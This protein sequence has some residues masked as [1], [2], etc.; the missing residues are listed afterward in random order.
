MTSAADT[1]NS[2]RLRVLV[3]WN[4]TAEEAEEAEE[5]TGPPESPDSS[6][7]PAAHVLPPAVR[8]VLDVLRARGF[9]AVHVNAEDDID[10][11]AAAV[12]IERPAL[13]FN[14]VDDF[15]GDGA[16]LG[17]LA[18]YLE[19]LDVPFVGADPACLLTCQDRVQ[20]RL[21]LRDAGVPV[22]RF[23]TVRDVELVASI[24]D[25]RPPLIVTQAL[26]D[27]YHDEGLERP[28][29]HRSQV[30]ERV[31]ALAGEYEPP[32]LIEEYLPQ[33]R[34]HALVL[35]HGPLDVLPLLEAAGASEPS[36][37]VAGPGEGEPEAEPWVLAELDPDAS[38]QVGDLA[39]R[40]YRALGCRDVAC[41]DIYLDADDRPHVVDVRPVVDFDPDGPLYAAAERS[42]RGF[43]GVVV[44]LV[45]RAAQR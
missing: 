6:W 26:D 27:V 19:L 32:F 4:R 33:R 39:R 40:S 1:T 37:H 8:A 25:L 28:L 20:V 43:A 12:V 42:E 45:Q 10:R 16:L 21:V 11:I 24:E 18:A 13:I 41:I 29:Y 2:A 7:P 5:A 44:E 15:Y 14:L 23:Q 9:D 30:V 38:A 17:A 31:A 34:L 35:G 36:R 22:P 3:L